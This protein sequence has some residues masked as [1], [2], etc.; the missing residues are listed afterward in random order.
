M[1]VVPSKPSNGIHEQ[2]HCATL[3]TPHSEPLIVECARCGD[4]PL[5]TGVPGNPPTRQMADSTTRL[6]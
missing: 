2:R 1:T 3:S 6:A 5:I 4:G